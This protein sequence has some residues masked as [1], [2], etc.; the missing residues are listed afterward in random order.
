MELPPEE[1]DPFWC[2]D[3]ID[4]ED[5]FDLLTVSLELRHFASTYALVWPKAAE[6]L[7]QVSD[8]LDAIVQERLA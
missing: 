7:L 3:I 6:I 2:K 4:E 5:I 8:D 1:N